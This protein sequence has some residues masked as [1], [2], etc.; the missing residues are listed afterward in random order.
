MKQKQQKP[1]K[2]TTD[3][4]PIIDYTD[5][6]VFITKSGYLD[7]VQITCKDLNSAKD[8]DIEF[9]IICFA[10]LFK[11]YKGD[12]KVIT[13]NYPA[14][15]YSQI[16]YIQHLLQR[17]K[18]P[19]C[20][21]DLQMECKALE[22]AHERF[23]EREFYLMFF[24]KNEKEYRKN[25]DILKSHLQR[26]FLMQPLDFPKKIQILH[27]LD[28]LNAHL[29]YPNSN[30]VLKNGIPKGMKY[31][32]Y[33]LYS[34]QPHGNMSFRDE[35]IVKKGDGYEACIHVYDYP[36]TV[37]FNWLSEVMLFED[38]VATI[39]ISTADQYQTIKN[40]NKSLEE[41][42]S[43]YAD[44]RYTTDR[45]D[46]QKI[47]DQ[48]TQ[49]YEA[50]TALGEVMKSIHI[51]VFVYAA[52][53]HALEDRIADIINEIQ[54]KGYKAVVFL[55]EQEY[56]WKSIYLPY[57]EQLKLENHRRGKSMPSESVAIG[58]PYHFSSL[59]DSHGFYFGYTMAG[60][61]VKLDRYQKDKTR[62]SYCSVVLGNMGSGK[63]T[64]LKRCIK[65]DAI[66]GNYV[67]GYATNNEFDK[68]INY[69]GGTVISLDGSDGFLNALQVYKT[70]ESESRSFL[71]HIAKIS[72]FY[73]FL[74]PECDTY[75]ISELEKLVKLL[76]EKH[77]VYTENSRKKITGLSPKKYPIWSDFLQVIRD[78]IY[79]DFAKKVV[80]NDI[81]KE[82]FQRVEKIELV[83]EN[84]I[85]NYGKVFNGYSSIKDFTKDKLVFFNVANLKQ[86]GD[87]I[88][89]AQLFSS[90]SLLWDNLLAVGMP[91]KEQFDDGTKD[92]SDVTHFMIY[93]DEA[94]NFVN[95][96]KITAVNFL[97]DYVRESRKYFGGIC[98]ATQSI[99][100]LFPEASSDIGIAAIKNLLSL[101]QYKFLFKQ[102]TEHYDTL[103][104]AF[105]G[106]LPDNDL[107]A[108]PTFQQGE[109]VLL[110]SG[111]QS[112]RFQVDISK[113]ELNLF[114]G[115]A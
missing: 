98:F 61:T 37:H 23:E 33:L 84:L 44:A 47:Y 102:G 106:E 112:I 77:M 63:S 81:S 93:M 75:D 80:R 45:I 4:T 95:A 24:A 53:K 70:S 110:I 88:F 74:V 18:N 97:V 90:L 58:H 14:D 10:N 15:T 54:S 109:C 55:N 99:T 92:L 67:R 96:R 50:M 100:D 87:H 68:L 62:L 79:L 46:A 83:I 60:G 91:E 52:T 7:F 69:Y 13:M 49:V 25:C 2:Q 103:R 12:L 29:S 11:T 51:R 71:K 108:L 94:H 86:Y 48:L 20:L 82:R 43:R 38:S 16:G 9:D 32:P 8:Y 78:E 5:N 26:N 3:F 39:D 57:T 19:A 17:T 76:Y 56:E 73:R 89:D 72:T 36:D 30:M 31:N 27:K 101:A 114:T 21:A 85:A 104:N 111:V 6:G 1:N 65:L 40:L 34:I 41:Q 107:E 59:N 42:S 115:G 66:A 28:N 105:R 35:R 22:I 113:E 64:L